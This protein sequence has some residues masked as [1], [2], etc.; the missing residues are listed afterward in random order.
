MSRL[1]AVPLARR[2]SMIAAVNGMV[3]LGTMG[4]KTEQ[5][6]ARSDPTHGGRRPIVPCPASVGFATVIYQPRLLSM[7]SLTSYVRSCSARRSSKARRAAAPQ[8]RSLEID[9]GVRIDKLNAL[10]QPTV[11]DDV[12]LW[13]KRGRLG[14]RT[15]AI[16]GD[17]PPRRCTCRQ[18][19]PGPPRAGAASR[20]CAFGTIAGASG[21][22]IG[23]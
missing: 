23:M 2:R 16:P 15:S 22:V 1:R 3:S 8:E 19:R 7:R 12:G 14:L 20:G 21:T 6:G 17:G 11:A 4:E 13:F 9:G 18:R 5:N 10:L